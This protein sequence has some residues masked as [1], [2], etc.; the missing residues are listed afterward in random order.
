VNK[1]NLFVKIERVW[2][3]QCSIDAD[4]HSEAFKKAMLVMNPD[5]Y[6]LPIKLEQEDGPTDA[7]K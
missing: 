5:H 7:S 1:Y 6:K 4:D 3:L 2:K